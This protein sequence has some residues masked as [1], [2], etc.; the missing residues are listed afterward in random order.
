MSY[1]NVDNSSNRFITTA[2]PLGAVTTA[3]CVAARALVNENRADTFE[4]TAKQCA[5]A[6]TKENR[7]TIMTFVKDILKKDK[8]AEQI[9]KVSD[10]RMFAIL[11]AGGAIIN[12]LA[13]DGFARLVNSYRDR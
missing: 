12:A 6:F 7:Q 13:F 5:K 10:K 2:L 3:G 1:G 9:A 11:A 8:W 4:K